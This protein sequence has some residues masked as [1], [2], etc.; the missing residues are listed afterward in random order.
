MYASL[1]AA[2]GVLATV[3]ALL[4][5]Q[6]GRLETLSPRFLAGTVVPPL[7]AVLGLS[8]YQRRPRLGAAVLM[9]AAG[10]TAGTVVAASGDGAGLLWAPGA[11]LLIQGAYTLLT[12]TRRR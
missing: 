5:Q 4:A 12:A 9:A 7:L 6:S 8:L 10:W 2:S 1:G 11:L 3:A